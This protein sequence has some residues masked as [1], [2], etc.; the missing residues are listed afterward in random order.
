M[1]EIQLS[2][3]T[4][5]SKDGNGVFDRLMEAMND[6][7][8]EEHKKNRITGPDYSKVYLGGLQTTMQQAITFLLSKQEADKK[9]ELLSQQIETEKLNSDLVASQIAKISAEIS[10]MEKQ[11]A[12][13]DQDILVAVQEV[14]FS[15]AKVRQMENQALLTEAQAAKTVKEVE[16]ADYQARVMEQEVLFSQAKVQQMTYE[17]D[18]TLAKTRLTSEQINGVIAETLVTARTADKVEQDILVAEQQVLNMQQEVLKTTQEV[19]NM[20]AQVTL[21][22]NQ[23]ALVGQQQ[24]TEVQNTTFTANRATLTDQQRLNLVSEEL[25]IDAET[26]VVTKQGLKVDQE[27]LNLQQE[28]IN[29]ASV[30]LKTDAETSLIG[31]NEANAVLQGNVITN[32]AAK[33]VSET[34]LLTQKR[35]TERAQTEDTVTAGAVVGVIGKQKVLYDRQADGFLRDAEQK[36]TKIMVDSWAIRQST[37]GASV[38]ANGLWDT[39]IRE[40][41][42]QAMVGAGFDP[43]TDVETWATP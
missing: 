11:E 39:N 43:R 37:D 27:V 3:L 17:A 28:V 7:I 12:K 9:A 24:L 4:E 34:N 18:L 15:R 25:K 38:A 40:A 42:E 29:L 26:A 10:L 5:N 8:R 23:A 14:L 1:A 31:Q 35:E 13:L 36:L 33:V 30:R 6:H 20:Q 2:E 19:L 22:G 41:V 32:T 21:T 16:I